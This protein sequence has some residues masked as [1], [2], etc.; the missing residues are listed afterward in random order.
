MNI[1][2]FKN[3]NLRLLI[4]YVFFAGIA[5]IADIGLLFILTEFFNVWY[6]YSA[7]IS[8]SVGMVGNYSLNKYFNFKNKSNKIIQQFGLFV[9]IALI[10]LILNQLILYLLV[11]FASLW[12]I[13]AKIISLFIVLIWSFYGHKKLTFK[14]FS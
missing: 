1:I 14:V 10:G 11:E 3:E 13:S 12:Y 2:N 7:A 5:T 8:Y 9:F 4:G 6:F